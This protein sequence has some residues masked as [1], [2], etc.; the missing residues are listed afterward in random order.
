MA[1][2]FAMTGRNPESLDFVLVPGESVCVD[3]ALA[4]RLL[5]ESR[6][7]GQRPCND[8]RALLLS[9]T[10]EHG[11]FRQNTQLWFARLRG[12]YFL[13]DGQH[14][15]TAVDL[16]RTTQRFRIEVED[17]GNMGEVAALYCRFD[18]PGGQRSLTQVSKSLGL[19]DDAPGGLRPSMAAL[20]LRAVPL[21]MIDLKPIAPVLRP[22]AVRD[23]D[24][25]KDFAQAWKPAAIQYQRCLE[26]SNASRTGRFRTAGVVAVALITMRYQETAAREFWREAIRDNALHDTD[27][28]HTLHIDFLQRRKQAGS[29]FV[30]A[31]AASVAWNAWMQNKQL[32]I[33]KVLGNPIRL[34][35]TPICSAEAA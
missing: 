19:H 13:V 10:M 35:G 12:Q 25:K 30:L 3:P 28:R 17:C 31:E 2:K 32:K 15:L 26:G 16:S 20:L 33:I 29:E 14:R 27:P 34:A 7:E 8:E 24:A 23:L 18:Q 21:L 5:S 11:T 4:V 1:L 6:Y 9:E 22:R